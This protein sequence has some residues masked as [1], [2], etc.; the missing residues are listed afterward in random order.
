MR[1]VRRFL[2]ALFGASFLA[3]A[4]AGNLF[5]QEYK[6]FPF[7]EGDLLA[8]RDSKT[9]KYAVNQVLKVDRIE[10]AKGE[11]ISFQGQRFV[12]TED[13]FL[14]VIGCS[15]GEREFDSIEAARAAAQAGRWTVKI[16]HVPNRA[17]GSAA[18]QTLI[19]HR[20][21][22]E[23]DLEGYRVWRAAYDKGEAGIF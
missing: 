19:G 14:L 15:Y 16:A 6:S 20:A 23:Q 7:K 5:P 21:V 1:P 8:S 18:G 9:G 17:P 3:P 13:D 10:I 4:A 22:R 11:T 2:L 12:A